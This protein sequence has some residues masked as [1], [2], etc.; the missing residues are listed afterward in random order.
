MTQNIPTHS[1]VRH[2]SSRVFICVPWLPFGLESSRLFRS[3]DTKN[4]HTFMCVLWLVPHIH[5]CAMTPIR[6]RVI[7]TMQ[8]TW[9]ETFQHIDVC[10]LTSIRIRVMKTI[11]EKTKQNIW[12]SY[13]FMRVPWLVPHIHMCAMTPIRIRVIQTNQMTTRKIPKHSSV[14]HDFHSD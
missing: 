2:A 12:H 6:I 10:A 8:V 13:T 1:C 4:F 5:M 11:A 14:C 7:K 3:C 9:Q